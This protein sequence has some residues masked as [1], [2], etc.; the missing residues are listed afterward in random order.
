MNIILYIEINGKFKVSP[1]R[2]RR[3][4]ENSCATYENLFGRPSEVLCPSN[5]YNNNWIITDIYFFPYIILLLLQL[6]RK[7][8]I[9]QYHTTILLLL[10]LLLGTYIKYNGLYTWLRAGTGPDDYETHACE[11]HH[12]YYGL[13]WNLPIWTVDVYSY[14]HTY[15]YIFNINLYTY[16]LVRV[17]RVRISGIATP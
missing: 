11:V 16:V 14:S 6:V 9:T 15:I 10:L 8:P 4:N 3:W 13:W 1:G 17:G 7:Y 12:Y 5:I 2:F